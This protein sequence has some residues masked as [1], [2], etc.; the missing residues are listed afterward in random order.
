MRRAFVRQSAVERRAQ[1]HNR[2]AQQTRKS[3][4]MVALQFIKEFYTLLFVWLSAFTAIAMYKKQW[5][6]NFRVFAIFII[7][8]AVMD[9]FGNLLAFNDVINHFYYNILHTI[10]FLVV[11]YFFYWQLHNRV[12]KKIINAYFIGFPLFVLVDIFLLQDYYR[13]LT[14][15]YVVGGSMIM[16]SA[17]AY[18]WQLYTREEVLNIFRDA[19]FWFSLAYLFFFA[20]S[21]PY[22]GML[23][24]LL[25]NHPE[26]TELYYR[27]IFDGAICLHNLF[28]T[29]GFLCMKTTVK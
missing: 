9:T 18:L 12:L 26:F 2:L 14:Y 10:V 16:I 17:I 6:F 20:V 27:F 24:Y 4:S 28:I 23:N 11:P 22:F 19:V 5:P 29:V 13:L 8:Y 7:V 21:V 1:V 25:Q 3:A 15:S